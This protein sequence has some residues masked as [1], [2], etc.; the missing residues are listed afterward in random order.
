MWWL[1]MVCMIASAL[2][3]PIEIDTSIQDAKNTRA[4]V[5]KS[6]WASFGTISSLP[7]LQGYP[8]VNI[9]SIADDATD[10]VSTGN[11]YFYLAD[12]DLTAPDITADN[13]A[14]LTVTDEQ[15]LSCSNNNIDPMSPNCGRVIL[16][17]TVEKVYIV[18]VYIHSTLI[19]I[20]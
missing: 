8:M 19:Y 3:N 11:I 6:N 16:S 9:I 7:K 1:L 20:Y 14:T 5:H 18:V 2:A 12:Y 13:V 10:S 15:D 4:I 17:G